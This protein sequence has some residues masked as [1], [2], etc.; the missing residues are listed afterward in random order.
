M[1]L[2]LNFLVI[3]SIFFTGC[4]PSLIL[5][6]A[7]LN[8]ERQIKKAHELETS[9]KF[10]KASEAYLN[11][12]HYYSDTIFYEE[13][14]FKCAVI[15]LHPDNPDPDYTIALKLLQIYLTLDPNYEQM[16]VA[17]GY[18]SVLMQLE[19]AY[20]EKRKLSALSGNQKRTKQKLES[21]LKACEQKAEDLESKLQKIKEIDVQMHES[22][23]K[24]RKKM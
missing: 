14:L 11:I 2:V 7:E 18:V 20:D 19:Q 8:A 12:I 6:D 22:R 13:A 23:S 17:K 1:R 21:A 15:N 5:T 9:K 16:L 3:F 24:Q 10:K 4:F